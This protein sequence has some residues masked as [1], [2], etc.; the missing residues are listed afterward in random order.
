MM[1]ESKALIAFLLWFFRASI[2]LAQVRHCGVRTPRVAQHHI[3]HDE[4]GE[5]RPGR[6]RGYGRTSGEAEGKTCLQ[7]RLL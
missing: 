3:E 6:V 4:D 5:N 1:G 7:M 2:S